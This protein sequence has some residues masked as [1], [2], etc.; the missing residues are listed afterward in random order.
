ML[1]ST[2]RSE[3]GAYV[4]GIY[5]FSFGCWLINF[6]TRKKYGYGVQHRM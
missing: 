6:V 5:S 3:A 4:L 1:R 2:I